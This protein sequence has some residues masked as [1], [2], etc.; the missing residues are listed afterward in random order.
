VPTEEFD[1]FKSIG[2]GGLKWSFVAAFGLDVDD[3]G[4]FWAALGIE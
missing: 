1:E 3:D 4:I 2:C